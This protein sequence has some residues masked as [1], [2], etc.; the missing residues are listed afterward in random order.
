MSA[1]GKVPVIFAH[2]RAAEQ[3]EAEGAELARRLASGR[4]AWARS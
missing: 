2:G 3:C 1:E 4:R